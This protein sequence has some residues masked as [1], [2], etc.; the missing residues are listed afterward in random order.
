MPIFLDF[1]LFYIGNSPHGEPSHDM[2]ANMTTIDRN[3]LIFQLLCFTRV[4][5]SIVCRYEVWNE[6]E[7]I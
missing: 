3:E 5:Q 7:Y 1:P 6:L 4:G 2:A